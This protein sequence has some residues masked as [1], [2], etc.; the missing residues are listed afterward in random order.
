MPCLCIRPL[1]VGL[2]GAALASV[3]GVTTAGR[4]GIEWVSIPGGSYEMSRSEVTVGQYRVCVEAGSCTAPTACDWGEPNWGESGRD[5]H[6]VN[7]VSWADA[8][9]F[10]RW[11]GGRLPSESEWEYAAR[12]GQSYTYAGSN[13]IGDVAW[14]KDNS[15]GRTHEVCGKNRN[16]YGLCDMSG[17]VWEWVEDWHHGSYTGAPTDG[18]AWLSPTGSYRVIR[19]GSWNNSATYVR[20]AFRGRYTPSRRSSHLGFRLARD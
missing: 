2:L 19:G 15:G 10:A 9:A 5:D 6:P 12:G 7:C 3:C 8:Q 11:A 4:S 14:Y 16:G 18:T 20:V 17:N 1:F 13:T